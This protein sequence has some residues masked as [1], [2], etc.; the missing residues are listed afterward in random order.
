M[1]LKDLDS[2]EE[3]LCTVDCEHA[4]AHSD[5]LTLVSWAANE[6]EAAL[7]QGLSQAIAAGLGTRTEF[8][9]QTTVCLTGTL[10]LNDGLMIGSCL[11][12]NVTRANH[13]LT[14]QNDHIYMVNLQAAAR[15]RKVTTAFDALEL[16]EVTLSEAPAEDLGSA[17]SYVRELKLAKTA[18][19]VGLAIQAFNAAVAHLQSVAATRQ[20]QEFALSSTD[21]E[22]A[23]AK[24]LL[25]A[26]CDHAALEDEA[27][28]LA[29]EASRNAVTRLLD[30]VSDS[31]AFDDQIAE[32]QN[33]VRVLSA[34][35]DKRADL[36]QRIVLNLVACPTRV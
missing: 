13:M 33:R 2:A 4:V 26:A 15:T 9:A 34:L 21:T 36:N 19:L 11:C 28:L 30:I 17:K 31:A 14:V 23:A 18:V 20:S 3:F 32:I 7:L 29:L 6:P 10:T 27:Q 22:I 8:A 12:P 24:S 25:N 5:P 1:E 16:G 35:A